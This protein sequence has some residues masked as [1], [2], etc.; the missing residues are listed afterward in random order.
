MATA[1]PK[2]CKPSLADEAWVLLHELMMAQR[3]RF[4]S[5]AVE[6]E[7]HPGQAAAL[8]QMQ[9]DTPLP[10]NEIATIL[11]CDN[12][13]VT[14][15]VDR[16]ETRG[17]VARRPYEHDRRVK[18]VMLTPA[19]VELRAEMRAGMG[20]APASLEALSDEDQRALRDILRRAVA[21]AGE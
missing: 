3:R 7:L 18:H 15:L 8:M 6:H 4:L 9:P 11:H 16:L 21:G 2:R 1:A 12:S 5:V 10:M 13:N 20:Q 17:L 14:G 19:G